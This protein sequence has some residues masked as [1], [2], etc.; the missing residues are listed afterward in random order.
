MEQGVSVFV[1]WYTL[2][3][4]LKTYINKVRIRESERLNGFKIEYLLILNSNKN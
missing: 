2:F 4:V 1:I 3:T